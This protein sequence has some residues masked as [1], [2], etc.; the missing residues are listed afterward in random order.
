VEDSFDPQSLVLLWGG[1]GAMKWV[2]GTHG[3]KGQEL[4]LDPKYRENRRRW[5]VM[6]GAEC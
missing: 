4:G 3:D 1:E 5:R 6:V 2:T